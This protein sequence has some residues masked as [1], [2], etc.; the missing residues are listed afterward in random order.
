MQTQFLQEKRK[1]PAPNAEN[2]GRLCHAVFF[3]LC[4]GFFVGLCG[5][6]FLSK[7]S[8]RTLLLYLGET[9]TGD[10]PL[11]F[12]RSLC[13]QGLF[14]SL[15]Y[16]CLKNSFFLPAGFLVLFLYAALFGMA[17]HEALLSYVSEFGASLVILLLFSMLLIGRGY[18]LLF[19][20]RSGNRKKDLIAVIFCFFGGS[21]LQ[22]AL[23]VYLR[24]YFFTN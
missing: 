12:L 8:G 9:W 22:G 19:H 17:F 15:F 1:R 20:Y 2:S 11:C 6:R 16:G 10:V 23:L 5:G 3:F 21:F 4:F 24:A 18:S 7:A 13:V 14:A